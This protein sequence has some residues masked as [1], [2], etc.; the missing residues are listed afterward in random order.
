MLRKC[1]NPACIVPFRSL[2]EGKLFIAEAPQS[3]T[4]QLFE[5]LR[6]KTPRREHFWLCHACSNHFTLRFD[7]DQGMMTAPLQHEPRPTWVAALA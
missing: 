1:A 2:R 4:D 7:F 6:K 3:V 5:R